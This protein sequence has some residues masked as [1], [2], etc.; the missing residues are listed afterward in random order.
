MILSPGDN[1]F[2]SALSHAPVPET[3]PTT[4]I[5][6][7]LES[8][9]KLHENNYPHNQERFIS[10]LVYFSRAD[11]QEVE[12]TNKKVCSEY[13]CKSWRILRR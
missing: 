6:H 8:G 4:N 2:V 5:H 3:W 10:S 7:M 12:F 9:I 1:V 13:I 11:A